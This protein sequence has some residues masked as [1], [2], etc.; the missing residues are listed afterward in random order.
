MGSDKHYPEEAPAHRVTVDGFWID[1]TPVTNRQFREFV[2]ATGHVTFAEIPPDPKDYPGAL[3]QMLKA[4]SLVFTPPETSGRSA[5]LDANGGRSRRRQLA[6]ALRT[7][8]L[9]QRPRRSSGRPRRLPRCGGLR[10][11]G[12][13]G[14]ADRSRMGVCRARWARRRRVRLGRRFHAR[15][16]TPRQYVAGRLSTRESLRRRLSPHFPGRGVSAERLWH[17]RHDRQYLGVDRRLVRGQAR[18]GRR[19]AC[20]IPRTRAAVARIKATIHASRRSEYPARSSRAA[21]T[22]ARRTTAAAIVRPRAMRKRSIRRRAIS[23]SGASS[24]K[25]AS[26]GRKLRRKKSSLEKPRSVSDGA[27]VTVAGPAVVGQF[28]AAFKRLSAEPARVELQHR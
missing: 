8:Q 22:Y 28:L 4:A 25:R 26:N 21:R 27:G 11:M 9:D 5:R 2:K 24:E 20:C 6:P 15:R 17:L 13:Q 18:S 3:P 12:G 23:D 7:A 14:I 19:K 16:A 1:R 10:E